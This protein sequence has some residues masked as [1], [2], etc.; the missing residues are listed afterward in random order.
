MSE[1]DRAEV[2]AYAE[3]HGTAKAAEHFGVSAGTIRSWRSR[4]RSNGD[5]LIKPGDAGYHVAELPSRFGSHEA[6]ASKAKDIVDA[7]EVARREG[8]AT[9]RQYGYA[10]TKVISAWLARDEGREPQVNPDDALDRLRYAFASL[11][12]DVRCALAAESERAAW[13]YHAPDI[14]HVRILRRREDEARAE[15]EAQKQRER[16]EHDREFAEQGRAWQ[17]RQDRLEAEQEAERRAEAEQAERE[18]QA[19]EQARRQSEA[20]RR[21]PVG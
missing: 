21:A 15:R 1:H 12:D 10:P 14:E 4:E 7:L 11:P 2:L 17:E 8:V 9:A 18:R 6:M 20:L 13:A 5:P 16:E 3:Q 19:S